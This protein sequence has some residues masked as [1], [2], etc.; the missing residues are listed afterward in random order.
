MSGNPLAGV[1]ADPW[2]YLVIAVDV[3]LQ[4]DKSIVPETP[5]DATHLHL[6]RIELITV[7]R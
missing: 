6:Y 1:F 3:V 5:P 7:V 4:A 2:K